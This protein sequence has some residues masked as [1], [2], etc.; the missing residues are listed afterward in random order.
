MGCQY[1]PG[2]SD[3][4]GIGKNDPLSEKE[5]CARDVYLMQQLGVNTE[6]FLTKSF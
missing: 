1:Q 5:A 2:G 4:V 3:N 6:S